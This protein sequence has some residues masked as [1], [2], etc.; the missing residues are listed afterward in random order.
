M[1]GSGT[2]VGELFAELRLEDQLTSAM[3]KAESQFKATAQGMSA[4]AEL[5]VDTSGI[6]EGLDKADSE[7]RGTL[8]DM[9]GGWETLAVAG[10][11]GMGIK[12]GTTL[13][14]SI[15]GVIGRRQQS[16]QLGAALGVDPKEA[17][18][19]GT[20]AGK[21]YADNFGD[22]F[23]D[24]NDAIAAIA[25]TVDWSVLLPDDQLSQLTEKALTFSQ[26]FGGDVAEVVSHAGILVKTGMA[27]D[28]NEAFDLMT[29]GMQRV[30]VAMRGDLFDATDEYTTYLK[31][32]GF[33]GEEAFGVLVQSSAGGAIQ[34]DKTGDALKEFLIRAQDGS[35]TTIDAYQRLGLN[36][37]DMGEA[38]A[39]GGPAAR[40]AFDQ[41][42]SAVLSVQDPA[43]RSQIAVEL[44]GTQFEDLGSI[45]ALGALRPMQDALG[46]VPGTADT[47]MQQANDNVASQVESIKRHLDPTNLLDAFSHGGFDAVREQ[48]GAGIDGIRGLW[49]EYGPDVK[50]AISTGWNDVMSWWDENG[51]TVTGAVKGFL[52][53]A[54]NGVQGWWDESGRQNLSDW[55]TNTAEPAIG[56]MIGGALGGAWDLGVAALKAKLTDPAIAE[57]LMEALQAPAS[58]FGDTLGKGLANGFIDWWN[59]LSFTLP[60]I[61][62][63]PLGK[64][65]GGTVDFPD[66]PRLAAG[67]YVTSPTLAIVGDGQP[68]GRGEIVAPEG[69]LEAAVARAVGS[70]RGGDTYNISVVSPTYH[71]TAGDIAASLRTRRGRAA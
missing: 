65:G 70:H 58:I 54:W 60:E 48:V 41:I 29:A 61:D 31:Q 19:L 37:H 22:S 20:I 57:K 46:T 51:D 2:K 66:I 7:G 35:A 32:L 5:G 50:A 36:A 33:T 17:D 27:K 18:R 63:G 39:E 34:L 30:P 25:T 38:V 55:W 44:F 52:S 23:G 21:V 26:L 16:A 13:L 69:K 1:S 9:I 45:D 62:L 15:N 12:L 49:D 67:A 68:A 8:L 3:G 53:N 71:R 59:Q 10:I 47:A 43:Q 11:A 24:V 14:D 56:D 4:E 40:K 6:S 28:F 42:I 64:H